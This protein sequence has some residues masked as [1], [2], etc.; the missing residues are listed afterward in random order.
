VAIVT[1]AAGGIG[2]AICG[3]FVEEGM[4]LVALDIDEP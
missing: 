3:R 4:R 2:R 1:G